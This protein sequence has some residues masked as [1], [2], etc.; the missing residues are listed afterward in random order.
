MT[1]NSENDP[2][3]VSPEVRRKAQRTIWIL[4]TVMIIMII[5]P[6]IFMIFR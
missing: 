2:E 1:Q 3:E 5:L 6:F 4:Y